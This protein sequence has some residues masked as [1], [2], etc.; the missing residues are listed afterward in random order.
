M[1]KTSNEIIEASANLRE[2]RRASGLKPGDIGAEA[3]LLESPKALVRIGIEQGIVL[4]SKAV[5]AAVALRNT[6]QQQNQPAK[7]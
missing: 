6:R 1:R 4:H 5:T 7:A 2:N 3:Y